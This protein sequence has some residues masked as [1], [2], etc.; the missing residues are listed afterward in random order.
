M[1]SIRYSRLFAYLA[2]LYPLCRVSTARYH[3]CDKWKA[4]R[5]SFTC[6]IPFLGADIMPTTNIDASY[7][8]KDPFNPCDTRQFSILRYYQYITLRANEMCNKQF[9]SICGKIFEN[10][11][12]MYNKYSLQIVTTYH[13]EF[14][15]NTNF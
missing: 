6:Q 14:L 12:S 15:R 4:E 1:C 9:L 8:P 3:E 13:F 7:C 5:L 2:P 10:I 11:A